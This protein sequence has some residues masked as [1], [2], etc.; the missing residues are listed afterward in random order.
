MASRFP[1]APRARGTAANPPN[2]FETLRYES[3]DLEPD[4]E[5]GPGDDPPR[6]PRT[7]LLRDPSRSIV[8]TTA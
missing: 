6:D 3:F 7:T 8:A 2:R 1:S 4:V 5:A